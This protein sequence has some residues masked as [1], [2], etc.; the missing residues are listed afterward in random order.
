MLY[1]NDPCGGKV[2][3]VERALRLRWWGH[4]LRSYQRAIHPLNIPGFIEIVFT[5]DLRV[6]YRKECFCGWVVRCSPCAYGDS[7]T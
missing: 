1:G 4:V 3:W 2:L 6:N 5:L 7:R